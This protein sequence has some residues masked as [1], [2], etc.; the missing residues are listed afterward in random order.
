MASVAREKKIKSADRVLEIFEMF[1]AARQAVTVMDVA[2]ELNVPQSSTSELLGSLVRRGYLYRD[3]NARTFRPTARVALLGAWVQPELFRHGRLLP[4]MDTLFDE[5][6]SSVVL[7]SMIGLDIKHVHVV[8][9]DLPAALASGTEHHPLHSPFGLALLSV[10]Y[11]D[12]VRKLVHRLNAESAADLH[13]RYSDLELQLN[14][15]SKQGC[16]VGELGEGLAAVAVLLP[17]WLD[18]QLVVGIVGERE[19]ILE[20]ADRLVQTLRGAIAHH[21]SPRSRAA[22][23][24][25]RQP[26]YAAAG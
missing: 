18:E 12:N 14:A 8:G 17:Q 10:M 4:M 26:A 25:A 5:T 22:M 21:F 19:A 6:G 3:R 23:V 16:A 9:Q 1:S 15:V 2:R 20:R 13:V 7:A 24:P 11:R